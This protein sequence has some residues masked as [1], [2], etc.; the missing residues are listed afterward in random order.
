MS[1]LLSIFDDD[2]DDD[3]D[4]STREISFTIKKLQVSNPYYRIK[5][6]NN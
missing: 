4:D 3:D 2:D 6:L 5:I 1:C